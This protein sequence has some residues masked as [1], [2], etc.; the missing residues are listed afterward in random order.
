MHPHDP[1]YVT[2]PTAVFELIPHLNKNDIEIVLAHSI[3][4]AIDRIKT[5]GITI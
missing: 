5:H 1:H 4:F 3:E 2:F